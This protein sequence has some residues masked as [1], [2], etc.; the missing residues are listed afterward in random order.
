L[1]SVNSTYDTAEALAVAFNILFVE[2][3][4]ATFRYHLTAKLRHI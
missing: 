3:S 1:E 2:F 4:R